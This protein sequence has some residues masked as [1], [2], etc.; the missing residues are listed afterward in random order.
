MKT[1]RRIL[2]AAAVALTGTMAASAQYYQLAN[3]VGQ[4]IRPALTGGFNYKGYVDASYLKGIG[5]K[6]ADFLEI[7]TTQGFRYS[8]WFF[9]GVGAGVEAVFTNPNSEFNDWEGTA[10]PRHGWSDID[11][12]KSRSKTGW[13]I[14]LFTDFRFNIGNEQSVS[15]FID[16]RVGASFLVSNNY[17]AI[18]D[19][20]MTSSESFY[21]RPTLGMRIPLSVNNPKQALNIGATYQLITSN[22]WHYNSSSTT[23]SA[24]GVTI[25]FEW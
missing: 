19:G 17:L 18:G 7:T 13:V 25:G 21:L 4:L 23:L 20:Y 11:P 16:L 24:L 8:N 15:F 1:L 14:P 22:Y 5:S 10:V 9:M 2:L 6:N 3:Q 12:S